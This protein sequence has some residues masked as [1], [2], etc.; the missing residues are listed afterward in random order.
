[1]GPSQH[2]SS[3]GRTLQEIRTMIL[4]AVYFC[5]QLTG[6]SGKKSIIGPVVADVFLASRCPSTMPRF[7]SMIPLRGVLGLTE[8][9]EAWRENTVWV[10]SLWPAVPS[11]GLLVV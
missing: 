2:P 11:S 10:W 1:M 5:R 9:A 6:G 8:E 4:P 7:V 3:R